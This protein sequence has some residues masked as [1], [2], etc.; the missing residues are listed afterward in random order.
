VRY[1]DAGV[2]PERK[3]RLVD[4]VRERFAATHGPEVAVGIGGFA[5][6]YRAGGG[7]LVAT[8]DGVGTKVLLAR[9]LGRN[10]DAARDLVHHCVD[11][12]IATG[13]TPLFF[14]DYVAFGR[15]DAECF[16]E[17][18][19]GLA[20][21]CS[22]HGIALLGGET[23]EMPDVY[24]PDAYDLAGFL[25]GFAPAGALFDRARVA[26]GDVVVGLPSAGLHT[27]GFSLARRIVAER[28]LDL[29]R[30]YPG[31]GAPLGEALL[32]EHRSYAAAVGGLRARCDV[33]G[34]AHI[35]GGGL[36]EN[37]P[38]A[39]G[40]GL[41]ARLDRSRWSAP[42]IFDFLAREGDVP[43]DDA[44]RAWNCGVGL[45]AIVP[46][47]EAAA[48]VAWLRAEGHGGWEIGVVE[49]GAGGVVFA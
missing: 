43:D 25:V 4:E 42:P 24:A 15:L 7:H 10:R 22:A 1:R 41:R 47:S 12:C 28:R 29:A 33:R 14:L 20:D 38:R 27:N 32:A 17:I 40:D 18:A 5:G 16:R 23:A 35:T 30:V 13:A 2:D 48:A 49:P 3:A 19:A 11:D 46:A 26:E 36:L 6:A 39:L 45:A 21:A 37:L 34:I 31:L 44:L 9:A 8:A